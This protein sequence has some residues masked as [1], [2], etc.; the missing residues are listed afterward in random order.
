MKHLTLLLLSLSALAGYG[1][2]KDTA[3]QYQYGLS[4][5]LEIKPGNI[6]FNTAPDLAPD[7]VRARLI[8]SRAKPWSVLFWKDGYVVHQFGKD[9]LYLDDRKKPI[10]L[11]VWGVKEKR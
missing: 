5:T 9:D 3:Y 4:R 2:K 11:E 1:Q 8:V 7:T 10:D 6:M